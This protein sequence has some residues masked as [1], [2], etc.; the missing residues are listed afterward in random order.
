[1]HVGGGGGGGG[2]RRRV[3]RGYEFLFI[4]SRLLT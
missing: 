2:G 1:V 3:W 4:R